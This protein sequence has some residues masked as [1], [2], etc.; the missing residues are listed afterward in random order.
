MKRILTALVLIVAVFALLFLGRLWMITLAALLV[1]ELAAW[2][3]LALARV[4]AEAHD[5]RLRIPLGWMIPAT[6]LVFVASLPN[7]PVDAQL[8]ILSFVTLVLFAWNGFRSPANQVLPDTA[9]GL[10][11][12]IWI[13]YPLSLIPLLWK[14]EDGPAL[15]VFLMLAVWSGDIAALYVGRA[16][17]RHKLAPRLSPGKTW[18][19]AIASIAGSLLVTVGLLFLGD[20]LTA[21]GNLLLHITEPAWQTL[22][23]AAI[24]NIAAQIGDLLESAV[25]RGA[26]VKDSGTLLPGHGGILDRI[27]ALLLATP[28]LWYAL[29][30]KDAAG[31]GRF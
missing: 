31:L 16:I 20:R 22:A 6:A 24:L 4:G 21:R 29:V 13:V 17:G 23:L 5:A 9:Q 15:V 11:G 19:G 25:K 1:A 2:E 28:V 27:D 10:F 7:V 8:S 3:F 30:L 14:T 18:E 26:G 12:L